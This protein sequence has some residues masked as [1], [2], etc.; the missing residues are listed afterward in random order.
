M[1]SSN[2]SPYGCAPATSRLTSASST[3]TPRSRST[4][5]SLPGCRRPLRL[6]LVGRHVHHAG[7][8]AEHDPAV[9]GLQP[10][11]GAQAVAVQRRA[12]HAAVGE[13]DRGGAVPRLHQAAS[14][15]RRSPSGPRAGRPGPGR[16]PGS[17][18]SPRAGGCGRPARAA[19]A[20]CRT[21]RSRCRPGARPGSTLCR[22]SPNSSEASCDSRAR[23][24]LMLPRSVL[25]SPLWAII[26]Y[27]CASSQ[28]GNVFVEKR[29]CTSASADFVRG[30]CQVGEVAQQLR[31][32]EHALVDDRAAA[33]S[34][35]S[36][37]PGR[38]R[39]RPRGGSRTACARTRPGRSPARRRRPR[40]AA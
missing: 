27:G 23:I 37:A 15:R 10:A 30:S 38:R 18:S 17:S 34:S 3:I 25:I 2:H 32:G 26:R 21:W 8:R 9:L 20:R 36:R 13:R 5:K 24:Q 14:G 39:S 16:P 1:P 33:R 28:L 22:S 40:R 12:D 19:R 29:E 4:R 31:A 35:G 11:A 7:L 6:T